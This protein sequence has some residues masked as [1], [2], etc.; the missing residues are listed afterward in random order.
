MIRTGP[1]NGQREPRENPGPARLRAGARRHAGARQRAADW[2]R[3]E[4]TACEVGQTLRQEVA[5]GVG[6]LR[7]DRHSRGD[8]GRLGRA[9]SEAAMAPT[10]SCGATV[11]S[12][13]ATDGSPL[14]MVAMSPTRWIEGPASAAPAETTTSATNVA[15]DSMRLMRRAMAHTTMV[16]T[17]T[18]VVSS[19]HW[20]M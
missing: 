12:G 7:P 17:A 6:P 9:T 10:S 4:P 14:G 13:S 2:Q 1:P 19:S 8:T 3:L 18:V 11:T 5:G 15:M 16:A 20:E